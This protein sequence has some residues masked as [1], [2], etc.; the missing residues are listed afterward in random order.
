[1]V[2]SD[3]CGVAEILEPP[4]HR[5]VPTGKV[6]ELATAL[7]EVLEGDARNAAIAAAPE[8]RARLD[9]TELARLQLDL[10]HEAISRVG[11]RPPSTVRA[12]SEESHGRAD[13]RHRISLRL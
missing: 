6:P 9:W 2:V 11:R 12:V 1:M 10:Y 13:G 4:A 3:A 8:L 7:V 5:V